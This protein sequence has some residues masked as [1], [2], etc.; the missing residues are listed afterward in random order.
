MP[1]D[2]RVGD[3]KRG[4][5]IANLSSPAF[6]VLEGDAQLKHGHC[7]SDARQ[8]ESMCPRSL[9]SASPFQSVAEWNTSGE[10]L[11]NVG[12]FQLTVAG[13]DD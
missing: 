8:A 4:P 1:R 7:G 11:R 5:D 2:R 6:A 12:R 13:R 10:E 3:G 9:H